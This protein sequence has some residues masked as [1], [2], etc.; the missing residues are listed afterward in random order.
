MSGKEVLQAKKEGPWA[1]HQRPQLWWE[2]WRRAGSVIAT[3]W[4]PALP[5]QGSPRPTSGETWLIGT[6]LAQLHSV[7]GSYTVLR[8][9]EMEIGHLRLF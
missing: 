2:H 9:H 4:L 6:G 5:E 8:G 3:W 7:K 1:W